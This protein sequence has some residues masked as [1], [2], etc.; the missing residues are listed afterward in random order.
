MKKY[1]ALIM[2]AFLS[3]AQ[4]LAATESPF[5]GKTYA[6]EY[7]VGEKH[8]IAGAVIMT[9]KRFTFIDALISPDKKT[10]LYRKSSGTYEVKGNKYH[11]YYDYSTCALKDPYLVVQMDSKDPKK[12]LVLQM[13]GKAGEN[14]YSTDTKTKAVSP[15]PD[16]N[17]I[18]DI[19]CEMIRKMKALKQ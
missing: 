5:A 18:E 19:K 6:Y 3:A 13:I 14:T 12:E 10:I 1:I 4:G 9:D 17:Y 8:L 11:L 7:E 2:I 16:D 15:G